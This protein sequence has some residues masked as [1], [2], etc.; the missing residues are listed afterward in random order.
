MLT[1]FLFV[2]RF[3]SFA[4][5]IRPGGTLAKAKRD[6]AEVKEVAGAVAL[7]ADAESGV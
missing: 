4:G 6:L 7:A 3:Y 5:E 2:R 1:R